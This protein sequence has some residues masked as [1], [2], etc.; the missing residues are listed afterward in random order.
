M[1]TAATGYIRQL[2]EIIPDVLNNLGKH[3]LTFNTFQFE[4]I[5]SDLQDIKK[6]QIAI[7]LYSLPLIWHD[8]IGNYL[9]VSEKR[10]ETGGQAFTHLFQ[11]QPYVS[12]YSLQTETHTL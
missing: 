1:S 3:F 10:N 12:I 4:I 6:H 2:N 7:N 5:N 11:L 8:T 9:L